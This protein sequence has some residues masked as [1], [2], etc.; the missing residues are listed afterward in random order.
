MINRRRFIAST[1]IGAG[2]LAAGCTPDAPPS[3]SN[4]DVFPHIPPFELDEVTVAELAEGMESGRWT[5][6]SIAELYLGRIESIDRSGPELRSLIEINPKAVEIADALDEERGTNGP[7][8]PLHGIPAVVKDNIETA[9]G[10]TTTAGSLALEGSVASQ[11]AFIIQ[12]LREAGAV[13]LAKANL[14]EW[15]NFRS[16]NSSSGWSARGGQCRNPYALDHNPCGSSS[17]SAVAVSANMAPLAVGT[18]TDGSI[19]CPST[20]NGIVGIKPTV[21]LLS[22]SGII[23]IAQS[24]DTAGPM[25]RTV[26]DAATLL[27]ALTG[28]DP[29]DEASAAGRGRFRT[30]YAQFLDVAGLQGAR[31]GVARNFS[32]D[33]PVLSLFSTAIDAIRDAGAQIIDPASVPNVPRYADTEFE[34]FLYEFKTGLNRYLAE[35]GPSRPIR[36]LADVI[37]FNEENSDREMPFFGQDIFIAAEEKGPLTDPAYLDALENNRLYSRS[38]GID[39]VMDEFE[40]DA[41]IAPTGGP[42]WLTDHVNGDS[43]TGSSTR[44]AAVA[45]YPSITVPMGLVSELPI[46]ISFFGRAWSEPVLLRL[47]FAYEQTTRRRQGPKFLDSTPV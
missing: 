12:R 37:E 39:L 17:G 47:A 3:L 2:G 40:L 22:R 21:G 35:L 34:V 11:D 14:S 13:I 24:Q 16:R 43:G 27:G 38:Q 6:R 30:D 31:I 5:A 9:D 33:D 1:L 45:G 15:A 4:P 44:P 10:M 28:I 18:E 42:A 41:L 19:L 23:P 8:G 29:R 20:R 46:G 26:R 32:F 25:A 36:S 7:R